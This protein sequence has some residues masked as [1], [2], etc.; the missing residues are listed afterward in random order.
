MPAEAP[1]IVQCYSENASRKINS[2][3]AIGVE[4]QNVR[5]GGYC[6]TEAVAAELAHTSKPMRRTS[7]E[8]EPAIPGAACSGLN[9]GV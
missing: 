1:G 7:K 9:A 2:T 8:G 4:G 3:I 6:H 5:I